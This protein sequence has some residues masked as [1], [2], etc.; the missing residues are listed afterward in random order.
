MEVGPRNLVIGLVAGI[1]VLSPAGFARA[2]SADVLTIS[3]GASYAGSPVQVTVP[4]ANESAALALALSSPLGASPVD[5]SLFESLDAPMATQGAHTIHVAPGMGANEVD[6]DFAWN[7][8]S[9]QLFSLICSTTVGFA[10]PGICLG[11]KA[12]AQDLTDLLFP[13]SAFPNGAP[14]HVVFQSD[15]AP[16]PEP[17]SLSFVA[18]GITGF[19]LLQH[20]QRRRSR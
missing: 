18:G 19:L 15:A 10:T 17:G 11:E 16:V 20:L 12:E 2:L 8:E 9:Q 13:S 3:A 6:I 5:V 14:F 4:E 1:G 7:L